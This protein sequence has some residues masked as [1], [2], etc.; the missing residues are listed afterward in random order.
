MVLVLSQELT[1]QSLLYQ[2]RRSRVSNGGAWKLAMEK[3]SGLRL[4]GFNQG[5]VYT[6]TDHV[7]F[8]SKVIRSLKNATCM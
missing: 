8:G 7:W 1:Y 6:A 4:S 5:P 3:G 2:G